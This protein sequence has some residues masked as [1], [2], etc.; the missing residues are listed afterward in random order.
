MRN[1]A[2]AVVALDHAHWYERRTA[3]PVDDAGG[4]NKAISLRQLLV[5][6]ITGGIVP[7]PAALV[8]LLSAVAMHRVLFGLYLIVAFSA[9]LALVL[10]GIGLLM[11]RGRGMVQRWRQAR[12][13]ESLRWDALC[14]A[15]LCRHYVLR[16]HAAGGSGAACAGLAPVRTVERP[17]RA[18]SGGR[19]AWLGAGNA[20]LHGCGPRRR[21]VDHREPG[22]FHQAGRADRHD[23]GFR[24]Y[25]HDLYRWRGDH[26][27]QAHH[28]AAA[29][30]VHGD[31]GR[32]HAD[33]AGR[34][35]PDGCV[36]AA[37][38][39]LDTG[40]AAL[41]R[42]GLRRA[43]LRR[44]GLGCGDGGE[45]DDAAALRLVPDGAGRWR[46]AWC[47]GWRG[48]PRWRCSCCR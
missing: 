35:E 47:M 42:A 46:S 1:D 31:D 30:L 7:C 27:V 22:A 21:R 17:C 23:V 5:L 6:G 43:G 38:A 39:A 25:H 37:D 48:L 19:W 13:G 2:E 8:V 18:V 29:W 32:C 4:A 3:E 33:C 45:S 14:A 16:G 10:I 24:A 15:G 34:A 11:V 36:A 26:P 40:G 41:R 9:G 12:G 20:S 28:S 44:A